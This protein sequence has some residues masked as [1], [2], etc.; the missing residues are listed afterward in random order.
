MNMM[1]HQAVYFEDGEF[2]GVEFP[3]LPGCFSQGKDLEDAE[4]NAEKAL[5]LFLSGEGDES[6]MLLVNQATKKAVC[7]PT[8]VDFLGEKLQQKILQAAGLKIN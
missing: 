1:K 7:F 5:K 8:N 2:V 3:D 4:K 6:H